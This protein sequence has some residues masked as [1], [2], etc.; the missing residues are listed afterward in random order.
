MGTVRTL[1]GRARK[2]AY[3]LVFHHVIMLLH[4]APRFVTVNT[5]TQRF[6]K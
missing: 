2:F 6:S 3:R 1:S 5:T 4:I